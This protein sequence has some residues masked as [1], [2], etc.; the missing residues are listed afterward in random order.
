MMD[1]LK[2][3]NLNPEASSGEDSAK[4]PPDSDAAGENPGLK[5]SHSASVSPG[6]KPGAS[7]LPSARAQVE[8]GPSAEMSAE[9]IPNSRSAFTAL[10]AFSRFE[11]APPII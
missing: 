7:T 9:E 10:S 2:P 5:P 11:K 1:E 3:E 4:V 6:L 8:S